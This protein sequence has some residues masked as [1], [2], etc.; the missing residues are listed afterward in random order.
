MKYKDGDKVIIKTW[1]EMSIEYGEDDCGSY[2]AIQCSK[3][4]TSEME[5]ELL[6]ISSKRVLTIVSVDGYDHYHMKEIEYAW[7]DDMIKGLYEKLYVM[8]EDIQDRFSLLDFD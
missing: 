5:K 2:D 7:S 8:N 4:Y 1:E 6:K 3:V